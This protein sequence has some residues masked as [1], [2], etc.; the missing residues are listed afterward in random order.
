MNDDGRDDVV[1][2]TR[3]SLGDVYMALSTGTSFGPAR[4]GTTAQ[5]RRRDDA[6]GQSPSFARSSGSVVPY[7]SRTRMPSSVRRNTA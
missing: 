2:F 7:A 6:V 4:S 1:T 3:N 5:D